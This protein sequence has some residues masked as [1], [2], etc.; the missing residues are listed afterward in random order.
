M[1]KIRY[2]LIVT[3]ALLITLSIFFFNYVGAFYHGIWNGLVAPFTLFLRLISRQF[4]FYNNTYMDIPFRA[5]LY[6]CGFYIGIFSVIIIP[7][8]II[9]RKKF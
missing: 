5:F 6:D 7:Y 9:H 8:K 1:K 4:F 3:L 2:I